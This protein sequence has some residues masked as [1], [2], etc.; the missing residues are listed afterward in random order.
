MDSEPEFSSQVILGEFEDKILDQKNGVI[1]L[2]LELKNNVR[3]LH[4]E[5]SFL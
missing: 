2:V 4:G 5:I 1:V 3:D